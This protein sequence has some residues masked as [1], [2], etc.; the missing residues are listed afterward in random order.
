MSIRLVFATGNAHKLAEIREILSDSPWEILSLR[1]LGLSAE[2]EEN[3]KSFAENS[4]I[5][6]REIH[7]RL[8]EAAKA[9]GK[10]GTE[11]I[12]LADD[13]GICVD[14]LSGAP[15]IYSAR[16]LGHETPYEEKNRALIEKL[17]G[18]S[19]AARGAQF[20][21][22]I[23]AVL[24]DGRALHAEGVMP[25]EIAEKPA[26]CGGFGYDPVFWLPERGLTAAELSAE[27]KNECS[28]RGKALRKMR[29]LLQSEGI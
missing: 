9:S 12:V 15:G 21:C 11:D 26:G 17:S 13:S 18:L 28:H 24:P 5:K 3:G 1:E 10:A 19:G 4:E 20:V 29:E 2:A 23:C 14:A 27:E 16:W 8:S 7:D 22:D 6:A 25:G